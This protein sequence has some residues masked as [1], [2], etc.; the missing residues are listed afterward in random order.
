MSS[1]RRPRRRSATAAGS[2]SGTGSAPIGLPIIAAVRG[3][4]LGGGCELA[5]T[6]DMIVAAEDA[7]VRPARDPARRHARRRRDAAADPGDRQ[8][9]GDGD[10]PDRPDDERRRG[11]RAGPGHPGRAR[12]RRPS[13]R[14][15][16]WRPGSRR[17][18]RSPCA[19]PRPPSAAPHERRLSDGLAARAGRRSSGC[20]TPRTRPKG[21]AAFTE[22]RPPTWSGR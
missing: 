15:S 2:T 13:T 16:S 1:R 19:P 10:D 7:T 14:P 9:P 8:G 3:F 21:M 4:A 18:R 22:K 5:M 17:C 12:P 11:G 20:S 6:C